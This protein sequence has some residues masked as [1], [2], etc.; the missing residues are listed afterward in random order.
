MREFHA[1]PTINSVDEENPLS[2]WDT[3]QTLAAVPECDHIVFLF[4]LF[5]LNFSS[6]SIR[7][8]FFLS[9]RNIF[10]LCS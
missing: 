4:N 1:S 8:Y 6:L 10:G 5:S 2:Q 7:N 9:P 3:L